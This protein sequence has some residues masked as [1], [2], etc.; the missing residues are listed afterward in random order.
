MVHQGRDPLIMWAIPWSMV[1]RQE[2]LILTI[3]QRGEN[4]I[5]PYYKIKKYIQRVGTAP[6]WKCVHLQ[7]TGDFSMLAFREGVYR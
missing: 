1:G 3:G 7:R 4:I 2:V 6:I 5:K